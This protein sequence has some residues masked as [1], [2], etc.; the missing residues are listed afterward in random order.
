MTNSVLQREVLLRKF[1]KTNDDV[2]AGNICP[3]AS[4]DERCTSSLILGVREDAQWRLLDVD[5][6][7]GV[8]ELLS[9]RRRDSRTVLEGLGL[10]ADVE[11]C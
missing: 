10:S 1:L 7:S 5:C 3:R 2:I 8:D 9:N 6:V 11:D 4:R